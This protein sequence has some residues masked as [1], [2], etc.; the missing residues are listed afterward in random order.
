MSHDC[1]FSKSSSKTESV[2]MF[3]KILIKVKQRLNIEVKNEKHIECHYLGT[4]TAINYDK[5][6]KAVTR[7][8][9]F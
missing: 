8:Q 9:G 6:L 1:F 7:G 4:K 3:Q 2:G 5:N